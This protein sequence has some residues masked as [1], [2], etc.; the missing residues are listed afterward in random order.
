[1]QTLARLFVLIVLLVLNFDD[2]GFIF[3]SS[4]SFESKLSTV[5]NHHDI[6]VALEL[7]QTNVASLN[8]ITVHNSNN[9]PYYFPL[10]TRR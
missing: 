7:T 4:T 3:S 6:H 10:L 9:L 8:L 5:Q 1:M 2:L